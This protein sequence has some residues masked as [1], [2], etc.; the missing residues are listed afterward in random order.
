[1]FKINSGKGKR[2]YCEWFVCLENKKVKMEWMVEIK[3]V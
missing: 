1:M 3:I 2:Q